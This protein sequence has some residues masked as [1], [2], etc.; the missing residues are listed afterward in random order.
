[1]SSMLS[2]LIISDAWRENLK[3]PKGGFGWEKQDFILPG[4][5]IKWL[6]EELTGDAWQHVGCMEQFTGGTHKSLWAL[7]KDFKPPKIPNIF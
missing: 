6:V 4:A 2:H 1:M 3:N 7:H 5:V